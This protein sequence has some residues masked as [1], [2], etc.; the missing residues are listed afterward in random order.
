VVEDP[1]GKLLGASDAWPGAIKLGKGKH[2]VRCQVHRRL[3]ICVPG[4][5][6]KLS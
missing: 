3:R 5:A 1:K 4:P 6:A 2:R